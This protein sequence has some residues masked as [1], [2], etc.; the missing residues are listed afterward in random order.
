MDLA[1]KAIE[2]AKK[3][4]SGLPIKTDKDDL[5]KALDKGE[6]ARDLNIPRDLEDELE[7]ALNNGKTIL[8]NPSATQDQI[9]EAIRNIDR[10]LTKIEEYLMADNFTIPN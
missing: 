7:R 9:N 6:K 1:T 3:A 8:N 2:E 5:K 4:L 10:I